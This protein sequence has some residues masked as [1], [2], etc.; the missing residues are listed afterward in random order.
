MLSTSRRLALIV[1]TICA[2]LFP[3]TFLVGYENR[4][5]EQS[6]NLVLFPHNPL[7]I[8]T[9]YVLLVAA[10]LGVGLV[11]SLLVAM[12]FGRRVA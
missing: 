8:F 11:V 1:A 4:K 9:N 12:F 6:S 2:I 7:L 5:L 3:L 10:L